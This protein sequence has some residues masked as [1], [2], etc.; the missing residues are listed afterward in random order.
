MLIELYPISKFYGILEE[1]GKFKSL[2]MN[3]LIHAI[4]YDD[5][6]LTLINSGELIDKI[7]QY[8][9]DIDNHEEYKYNDCGN[10]EWKKIYM[11]YCDKILEMIV[12]KELP[13]QFIVSRGMIIQGAY[14]HLKNTK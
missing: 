9:R 3:P 4:F 14:E 2:S 5:E 11:D 13:D 8:Q 1:S 12:L 7:N 6:S 10:T